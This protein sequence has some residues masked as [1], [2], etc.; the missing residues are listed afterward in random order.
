MD[1]LGKPKWY[2]VPVLVRSNLPLLLRVLAVFLGIATIMAIIAA[3]LFWEST[4]EEHAC[5]PELSVGSLTITTLAIGWFVGVFASLM[6]KC[7]R[8][9]FNR[10]EGARFWSVKAF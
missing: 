7:H 3:G 6:G 1:L 9:N 10:S 5:S 4:N 8:M 2:G